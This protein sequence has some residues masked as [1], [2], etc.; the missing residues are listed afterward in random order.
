M[1]SFICDAADWD[2]VVSAIGL[3]QDWTD[4]RVS[5]ERASLI[6]QET[7]LAPGLNSDTT[8]STHTITLPAN[9]T[10]HARRPGGFAWSL[11]VLQRSVSIIAKEPESDRTA[12]AN[13]VFPTI[14][15]VVVANLARA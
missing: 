3:I 8:A 13:R 1:E 4:P 10:Q 12:E 15:R 7:L 9:F 6:L 2:D 5:A 11:G 14:S